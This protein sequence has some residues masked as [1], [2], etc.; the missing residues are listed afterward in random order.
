MEPPEVGTI[1]ELVGEKT[2]DDP[3]FLII[4]S[5]GATGQS[6]GPPSPEGKD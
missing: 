6:K 5:L 3:S 2:E 4:E 1:L